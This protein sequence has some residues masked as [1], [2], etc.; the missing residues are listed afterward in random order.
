MGLGCPGRRASDQVGVRAWSVRLGR[1]RSA[2]RE[3]TRDS[4]AAAALA[5]IDSA[6]GRGTWQRPLVQPIDPRLAAL[7]DLDNPD[8]PDHE[9]FRRLVDGAEPAVV[10]DLGC[11]TGLLTVTFAGRDR[12]VIG[13]DPDPNMLAVARQRPGH[14]RVSWVLGD[15]RDLPDRAGAVIMAG[16]VAMHIGPQDWRR[17]LAEVARS[18][19]PGGVVSF[20]TRNPAR[21]AW[22]TWTPEGSR[23]VRN[24]SHGQLVEWLE[25]EPPDRTGTVVVSAHNVWVDSGDDVIVTQPLTFRSSADVIADLVRAG[26]AVS[27]VYGGWHDQ[28]ADDDAEIFVFVA[29][30]R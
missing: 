25:A 7:H 28:P 17:T 15:S 9:F 23:S 13:I 20:E 5:G 30:K 24:T 29:T 8:G 19:Q 6:S 18:L 26:L 10:A 16:N 11:G 3:T 2:G 27:E 14:E 1:S 21:E 4:A 22:R 12:A